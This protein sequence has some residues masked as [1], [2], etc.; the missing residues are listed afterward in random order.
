LTL[1]TPQ[2]A[3]NVLTVSERTLRRLKLSR[4]KLGKQYRYRQADID[5]FINLH[6]EYPETGRPNISRV[7]RGSK[8]VGLQVLPSRAMLQKIR[9][10][11]Q[12]G[13]QAAEQQAQV[14]VRKHTAHSFGNGGGCLSDSIGGTR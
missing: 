13:G 5:G 1:L 6:L 9:L 11:Y 14:D 8:K 7:Q 4:V 10:G 2:E 12:N 3:A